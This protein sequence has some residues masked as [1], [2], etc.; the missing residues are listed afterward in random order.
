MIDSFLNYIELEKRYSHH[1][2]ISYRND[3]EQCLAFLDESYGLDELPKADYHQLRAWIVYLSQLNLSP[4]SINRKIATLKSYFKFLLRRG[5]IQQNPTV[6]IHS[7][8]TPKTTPSFV[9]ESKLLLL[10]EQVT[11]PDTFAGHRDKIILETLYGTGIRVS[12]LLN[13][14]EN[15]IDFTLQTVKIL[16]KGNKVR[17]IPIYPELIQ[18][19]AE[20][21]HLKK[22][23]FPDAIY[24][25]LILTDQGLPAYPMLIYTTVKKY[26]NLVTT[27]EHKSPH[28]LRHSFATH[29]LNKGADLNAIK[30]LLGHSTLSATQ[31]YTHNTLDRLKEIFEQ[32]H[33]KA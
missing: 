20:F 26:L 10:L 8:K 17:I 21:I 22:L 6:K 14:Q 25:H 23:E 5:L 2:L 33:P 1:T 28:T 9:E 13:L 24:E 12:E 16:G 32:A 15:N 27:Q 29:L 18:N 3:L 30:D 4:L 11:F 31:I 19:L 7:L